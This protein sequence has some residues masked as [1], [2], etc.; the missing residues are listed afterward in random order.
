MPADGKL[1]RP[2]V[3]P[4]PALAMGPVPSGLL[5]VEV[6]ER[7]GVSEECLVWAVCIEFVDDETSSKMATKVPGRV[8]GYSHTTPRA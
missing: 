8:G 3:L 2:P 5:V 4:L 6:T 7:G 1:P